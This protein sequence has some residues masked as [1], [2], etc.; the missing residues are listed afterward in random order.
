MNDTIFI[1]S[2]RGWLVPA[3]QE[4]QVRMNKIKAGTVVHATIKQVRS[5][6][7][8]Q[9]L[10]V[11]LKL[12]FDMWSETCPKQEYKGR[13]VMPNFDRFRSDLTILAGF[14]EPIYR[15]DGTLILKAKSI[16]FANMSAE[17]FE[18]FYSTIIDTVLQKVL[19]HLKMTRE[20]LDNSVDQILAFA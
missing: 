9:K 19:G 18:E 15:I 1:Y 20:D 3:S 10:F 17:E 14:Y 12:V 2:E 7:F 4:T 6:K 5:Y 8:L 11:M 13:Q 16:A